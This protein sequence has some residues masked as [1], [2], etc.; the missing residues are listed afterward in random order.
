MSKS[1]TEVEKATQEAP[2]EKLG[3]NIKGSLQSIREKLETLSK[4]AKVEEKI[5]KIKNNLEN[6]A[7]ELEKR[8]REDPLKAVGVCF[9]AGLTIGILLG[10]RAGKKE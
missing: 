6:L 5:D 10:T 7:E 2:A 9:L 8:T 3:E 4:D 1:T